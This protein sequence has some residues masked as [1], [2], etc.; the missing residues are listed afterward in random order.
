MSHKPPDATELLH[1][2]YNAPPLRVG[3][4]E[5]CL[6]RDTLCKVTSYHDA[7]IPWPQ[8]IPIEG[9]NGPGLIVTEELFRAVRT[10][11]AK[12]V[13][14]RC[15]LSVGLVARYRKASGVTRT[16]NPRSYELIRESSRR[17]AEMIRRFRVSEKE[18]NARSH[19]AHMLDLGRHLVLGY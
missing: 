12:E 19:R 17:G 2:P 7:L 8:G 9:S 1:G 16:N 4:R 18:C 14:W 13:Q 3:D 11:A 10:E 15:R 6:Y 5:H